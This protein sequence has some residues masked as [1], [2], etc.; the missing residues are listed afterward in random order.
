MP[1][2]DAGM[3]QLLATGWM[4]N[5]VRMV[6]ASFLVKHLHTRWQ[7]GAQHF[8]DHL[9]DADL[10][11]NQHGWQW[12]AGTGTDAAPYFRIFNPALQGEKFDPDAAY[13]RRWIPELSGFE[14]SQAQHQGTVDNSARNSYPDPIVDLDAERRDVLARHQAARS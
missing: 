8:L 5:R 7:V 6:T 2:V 13:I 11:S 10:A 1:L 14:L 9:I 4:H 3:R 12:V